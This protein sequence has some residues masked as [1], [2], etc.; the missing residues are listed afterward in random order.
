MEIRELAELLH[1]LQGRTLNDMLSAVLAQVGA[2]HNSLVERVA[3][4]ENDNLNLIHRVSLLEKKTSDCCTK[5]EDKPN[6]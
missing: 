5:E 4:L 3:R 2:A 1:D 6:G